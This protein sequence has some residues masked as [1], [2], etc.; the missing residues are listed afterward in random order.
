MNPKLRV[1]LIDD[2]LPALKRLSRLLDATG[3]VEVMGSTTN[4]EDALRFLSGN[5]PDVLF[6]DIHMPGMNGFELLARLDRQPLVV[7]TT[8]HD[9]YALQAFDVNS[10]D[11]LLKP[12]EPE[13]LERALTKLD[14]FRSQGLP[15]G[16]DRPEFRAVIE[17]LSRRLREPPSTFAQRIPARIGERTLFIDAARITHFFAAD[18]LTY[19]A[20]EGRNYCVNWTIAELEEKLEPAGFIRIHRAVL[21]NLEWI[22]DLSP[23]F[24][25]RMMIRLK[26]QKRTEL[27]VARDR[28]R[29]LKARLGL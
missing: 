5:Q 16:V 26:D 22:A 27:T 13:Q 4:P 19:A 2:E 12:V 6:L 29:P 8:A 14:R 28:V 20:T 7:F 25:G 15:M 21:L 10:I 1:Y 11:Y 17:D 24:A 9:R 18:R 3:R 23:L